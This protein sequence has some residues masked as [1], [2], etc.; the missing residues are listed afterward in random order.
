MG[1]LSRAM[2]HVASPGRW[3]THSYSG[4]MLHPADWGVAARKVGT[5]ADTLTSLF[6]VVGPKTNGGVGNNE[7]TPQMG[8]PMGVTAIGSP[9]D[10]NAIHIPTTGTA[11]E[12]KP[13]ELGASNE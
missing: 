13:F 4:A 11:P 1:D 8:A 6:T 12:E 9:T 10:P 7:W 2:M 3:I 5:G